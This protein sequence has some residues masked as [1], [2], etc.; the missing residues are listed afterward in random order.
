M[1]QS[2]VWILN[3]FFTQN[4]DKWQAWISLWCIVSGDSVHLMIICLYFEE[5]WTLLCLV[6]FIKNPPNWPPKAQ[7]CMCIT[8]TVLGPDCLALLLLRMQWC[9]VIVRNKVHKL[10]LYIGKW[11]PSKL[12]GHFYNYYFLSR[13]SS[14]VCICKLDM[15]VCF[16]DIGCLG[17]DQ[18]LTKKTLI[19]YSWINF[20]M[21][22]WVPFAQ[23]VPAKCVCYSWV[24]HRHGGPRNPIGSIGNSYLISM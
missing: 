6:W 3:V 18:I 20:E 23:L 1:F 14:G 24:L 7:V 8:P 22:R 12:S 16:L 19:L 21:H 15:S 9:C 5:S 2:C 10:L 13:N 11:L 17:I 4:T